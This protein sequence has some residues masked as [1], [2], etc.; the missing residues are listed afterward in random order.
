MR[1]SICLIVFFCFFGN[2]HATC[3]TSMSQSTPNTQLIDNNNGTVTDNK[4]SLM[5]KQCLEGV[6]GNGACNEGSPSLLSWTEALNLAGTIFATY[7]DW[8]LPN[9]KELTSIVEYQCFN[10][11]INEERFPA[12]PSSDQNFTTNGYMWSGSP[13]DVATGTQ[14]L[15]VDFSMGYTLNTDQNE[16]FLVRLV[17]NIE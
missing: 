10:P 11:A 9:I 5:W 15:I 8:R 2:V 7:T 12:V 17:R 14:A 4:T 13:F 6:S 1:I 16:R 3:N